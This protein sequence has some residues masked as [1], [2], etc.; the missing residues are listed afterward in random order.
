MNLIFINQQIGCFI[1]V[2]FKNNL[3]AYCLHIYQLLGANSH[4]II[5]YLITIINVR[6]HT[7]IHVAGR[8]VWVDEGSTYSSVDRLQGIRRQSHRDKEKGD[9]Q[10]NP[11]ILEAEQQLKHLQS[12]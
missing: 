1:V 10:Y 4:I 11:F 5:I 9:Y 12:M 6:I 7:E 2:I 3:R 8:G